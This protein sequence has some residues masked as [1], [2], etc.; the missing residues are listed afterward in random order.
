MPPDAGCH[1]RLIRNLSHIAVAFP[2]ALRGD[3]NSRHSDI[4]DEL[5]CGNLRYLMNT[6]NTPTAA[7]PNACA[8]ICVMNIH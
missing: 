3:N 7:M 5:T 8:V 6:N 1:V 2:Y 4:C